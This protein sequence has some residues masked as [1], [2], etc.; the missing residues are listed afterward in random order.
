[1]RLSM[2]L[3]NPPSM[4]ALDTQSMLVDGDFALLEVNVVAHRRGCAQL[5]TEVGRVCD[6]KPPTHAVNLRVP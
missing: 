1:M 4:E 6:C 5:G 2:Y 3:T